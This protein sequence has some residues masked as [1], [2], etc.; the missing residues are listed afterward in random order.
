[1]RFSPAGELTYVRS[2]QDRRNYFVPALLLTA[3]GVVIGL[4][5]ESLGFLGWFFSACML[6]LG[7]LAFIKYLT[8]RNQQKLI[9]KRLADLGFEQGKA[10]GGAVIE[11]QRQVESSGRRKKDAQEDSDD[12]FF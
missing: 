11:A 8:N 12:D 6:A 2:A 9:L 7:I 5:H 10:S 1:M 3:G 4:L